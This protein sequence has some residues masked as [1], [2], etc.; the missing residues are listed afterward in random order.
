M[1]LAWDTGTA[2]RPTAHGPLLHCLA[3]LHTNDSKRIPRMDGAVCLWSYAEIG[4][5]VTETSS[6]IKHPKKGL[7]Q[8]HVTNVVISTLFIGKPQFSFLNYF[9][10]Y[11]MTVKII[12][13]IFLS[14]SAVALMFSMWLR[15]YLM[16][17]GPTCVWIFREVSKSYKIF[18]CEIK[19]ECPI[20]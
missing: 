3:A 9:K 14:E 5:F 10:R 12:T 11:I 13:I 16:W 19:D 7:Y 4:I 17:T 18:W 1:A 2:Q 6:S 20:F 8:C 15:G